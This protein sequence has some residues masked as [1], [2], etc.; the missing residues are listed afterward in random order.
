MALSFGNKNDVIYSLIQTSDGNM[1]L[2]GY[3]ESFGAGGADMCLV[4][5]FKNT[6][7]FSGGSQNG[8]Q[9]PPWVEIMDW[10]DWENTYGGPLDDEAKCVIQASD[11]TFMLAGYTR[12]YGAGGSDM[13]LVKADP[14]GRYLGIK[15]IGMPTCGNMLLNKTYGGAGDDGANCIVQS[16]DGGYVL[17]GYTNSGVLSQSSWV[18][19]TDG[20]GNMM[21]NVVLAGK[22]ATS[23]I[24]TSDGGYAIAVEQVN[25]FG[26]IK[27]DSSGQIVWNQTYPGP[28]D[29]AKAESVIQTI[30]GGYALAGWTFNNGTG[31]FSGWLVKTDSDGNS[32]WSQSY[33]GYGF[34]SV[35]Q[36]SDGGYAMIGDESLLFV[37]DSYGNVTLTFNCNKYYDG[38][39][40]AYFLLQPSPKYFWAVFVGDES[41]HQEGLESWLIKQDLDVLPPTPHR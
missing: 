11:G 32:I 20:S 29:N 12:S 22:N 17:A 8:M 10:I 35:V 14:S 18:V 4:K 37:T 5:T 26:L 13:Y 23:L 25:S 39:N 16:S 2:A 31:I 7:H 3:T 15:Y 21:W 24:R 36:T 40:R 27:L 9:V 6:M 19:K 33:T 34:Y 30:D 38:F 1:A 28:S 41:S